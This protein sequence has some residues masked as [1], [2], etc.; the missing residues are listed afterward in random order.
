[1]GI[2]KYIFGKKNN[3]IDDF[4]N[5]DAIIIDVRSVGEYKSGAIANSIN[6]PLQTLTNKIQ[7]IKNYNKPIITCCASGMRSGSASSILKSYNIEVINGGTW[8]SLN[9]KL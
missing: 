3:K 7:S 8:V 4:L 5:R 1:M 2:I 6:I 9:K